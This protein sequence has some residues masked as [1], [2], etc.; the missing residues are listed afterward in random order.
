MPW[1]PA[2]ASASS[3]R[4]RVEVVGRLVDG[5]H[6]GPLPERAGDLELLALPEAQLVPAPGHVVGE[7]ESIAQGAGI[8]AEIEGEIGQAIGLRIRFLR[9]VGA[10]EAVCDR[11]GIGLDEA[12]G[13]AGKRRLAASV[14]AQKPGPALCE[15]DGHGIQNGVLRRGVRIGHA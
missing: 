7:V 2:S 13:D 15:G 4:G 6:V 1:K 10:E 5:E 8:A 12:A 9:A 3:A 14:V 11:T